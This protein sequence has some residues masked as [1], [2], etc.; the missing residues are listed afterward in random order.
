MPLWLVTWIKFER[1]PLVF[2]GN[3]AGDRLAPA[4]LRESAWPTTWE[5]SVREVYRSESGP[6]GPSMWL[7]DRALTALDGD[8]NAAAEAY[9]AR[10]RARA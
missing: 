8:L 1:F 9:M 2:Q 6:P 7:L 5:A 10:E 4:P 3:L